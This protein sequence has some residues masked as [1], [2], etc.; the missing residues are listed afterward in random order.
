M[1]RLSSVADPP[2]RKATLATTAWS[3]GLSAL[4]FQHAVVVPLYGE[5]DLA[6]LQRLQGFVDQGL[7][8]VVVNNNAGPSQLPSGCAH[9]VVENHNHGGLAGGLNAGVSAALA[10][11]A[12]VITLLDQDSSIDPGDLRQLASHCRASQAERITVVG[13]RIMD[14]ARSCDHMAPANPARLLITSGTTFTPAGWR[15]VGPL[16]EWMEIDYID[17]E[18]CSRARARRV[19]L[20]VLASAR[21]EQVFGQRHPSWVAH[22]LG[23]QLYSPYRRAIA[24]R[25]LR[26]LLRQAYVPWDIRLK[27]LI[28]M[29]IKP[30]LWLVLEPGSRRAVLL[31][32]WVG[33]SSPLEQPFPRTRLEVCRP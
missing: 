2:P 4:P 14:A 30:W 23:L 28:K 26:W 1:A 13:P 29:L 31:A 16:L 25:N 17:H 3:A 21:L 24:L 6:C 12:D 11:A 7:Q 22:R 18:W 27:E 10:G 20:Q 33:L 9:R 15:A 32:L 19:W 5:I 8:V